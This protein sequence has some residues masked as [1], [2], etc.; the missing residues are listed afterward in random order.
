M[1]Q[2]EYTVLLWGVSILI[3]IFIGIVGLVRSFK[4]DNT[5]EV[6]QR[7]RMSQQVEN[8]AASVEHIKYDIREMKRDNKEFHERLVSVEQIAREAHN[9]IDRLEVK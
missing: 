1:I 6:E 2:N 4:Q 7:A 8:I 5:K 3:G 9:R